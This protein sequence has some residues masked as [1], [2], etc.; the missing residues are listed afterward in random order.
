MQTAIDWIMR[1]C[2]HQKIHPWM[3]SQLEA[4][5]QGLIGSGYWGGIR[6]GTFY[7][8][9]LLSLLLVCFQGQQLSCSKP[10]HCVVYVLE[11]A[12]HGLNLLETM[13]QVRLSSLKSWL[14]GMCLSEGTTT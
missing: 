5:R 11:S 7:N 6:K 1:C 2:T 13:S 10:F 12:D 14:S 4:K 9:P 8:L 3:S